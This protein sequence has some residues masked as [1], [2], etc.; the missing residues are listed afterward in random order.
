MHI[1]VN[2]YTVRSEFSQKKKKKKKTLPQFDKIDFHKQYSQHWKTMIIFKEK[3]NV[4]EDEI[5]LFIINTE[6]E[7]Y[8]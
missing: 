2:V 3:R 4:T 7:K 8:V 6:K 5:S 1:L